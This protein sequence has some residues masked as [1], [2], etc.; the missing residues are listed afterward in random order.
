MPPDLR[1]AY[2]NIAKYAE[3]NFRRLDIANRKD[4]ALALRELRAVIGDAYRK[5]GSKGTLTYSEMQKFNRIRKL[6]MMLNDA[7]RDNTNHVA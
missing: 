2:E 1:R 4:Y 7:I 5:Y 3:L 6:D